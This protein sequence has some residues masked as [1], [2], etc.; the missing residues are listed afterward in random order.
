MVYDK[1]DPHDNKWQRNQGNDP[2]THPYRM[3]HLIVMQKDQ[4]THPKPNDR[5]YYTPNE[6]PFPGDYQ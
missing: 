4:R 1:Q 3:I 2:Q 6:F 5:K